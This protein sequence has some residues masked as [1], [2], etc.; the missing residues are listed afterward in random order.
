LPHASLYGPHDSLYRYY[1]NKF[2]EQPF[3]LPAGARKPEYKLDD[4]PHAAF[5]AMVSRLDH[6]V[7]EVLQAVHE[8]DLEE[9]TLIIFTSDNGPHHEGG[10]DPAFFNSSGPLRGVKR[11]LYEGGIRVPFIAVWK[12]HIKAGL[13]SAYPGTFWDLFPTFRQLAGGQPSAGIDGISVLTALTT[14][15]QP[16]RHDYLYWEFHESGGRQ[17]VRWGKWKGIRQQVSTQDHPPLELYNLETDPQEVH[18]IAAQHPDIVQQIEQKMQEAHVGNK[19]WPLLKN[20]IT[21]AAPAS[22]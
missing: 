10:G 19:D 6:Y 20:E 14:G 3:T 2:Y 18:N 12:G 9:N 1:I 15:N 5:A 21:G 8:L 13:R 22:N 17:A 7:G 16:Q 11:D 4:H